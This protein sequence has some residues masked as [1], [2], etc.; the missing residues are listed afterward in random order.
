MV[1]GPHGTRI[2]GAW[3]NRLVSVSATSARG[4]NVEANAPPILSQKCVGQVDCGGALTVETFA[5]IGGVFI[6]F[7]F[8]FRFVQLEN[9]F[10][11]L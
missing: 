5:I 9:L 4:G 2:G 6:F 8:I 11:S 3:R 7:C 10:V 1:F